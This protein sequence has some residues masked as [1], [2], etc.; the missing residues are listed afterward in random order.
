MKTGTVRSLLDLNNGTAP[1]F[2]AL[3]LILSLSVMLTHAMAI[4]YGYDRFLEIWKSSPWLPF[5]RAVLPM[6]FFLGGFLVAGSADRLKSVKKFIW[7]RVLRILPALLVEISLSALILG[8]LV[9]TLPL[10]KYFSSLLF[11]LYFLNALG[12]ISF[13]LPGVFKEHP[14][15]VVNVNLWTLPPD[16]HGYMLLTLLLS[17]GVVFNRKFFLAAYAVASVA[18]IAALPLIHWGNYDDT[19]IIPHSTM[20]IYSFFTGVFVYVFS[21]RVQVRKSY[22]MACLALLP[23]F[24]FKYT[25]F[26]AMMASCYL[27]LCIGFADLRNFPLIRHG[28]YSYGIYLYGFPLQQ[29]IWH[30]MPF[31]RTWW[32]LDIIA[33]PAA[34]CFAVLSWHAV[35]KPFLGLKHRIR[36]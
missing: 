31:A 17:T 18:V 7:F 35:E 4:C 16:L 5:I 34:L 9:T 11:M 32:I 14:M 28:D 33:L 2:D 24:Y 15:P 8:P 21:D 13:Y 25:L 30:Y 3:R 1:G 27:C 19:A 20:L 22:M 23:L 6:F 10:R 12:I 26:L 36:F 29:A